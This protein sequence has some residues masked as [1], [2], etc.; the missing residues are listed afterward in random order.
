MIVIAANAGGAW[1]PIGKG[2]WKE[3][4]K[5]RRKEAWENQKGGRNKLHKL[6]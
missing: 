4:R 1:T 5:E 3:G 6:L 2:G